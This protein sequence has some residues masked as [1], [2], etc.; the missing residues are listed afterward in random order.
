MT[1]LYRILKSREITLPTNVQLL[2]AVVFPVVIYGMWELDYKE[3]WVSK[4]WC[5]WTVVLEK[6]LENPLNCKGIQPV[7][8]KGNQSWIFIGRTDVEAETLIF[9]PPDAK[10]WLIGK[11]PDAGKGW[12]HVRRGRQRM[13]WLD[14]IMTQWVWVNYWSW[15]WI[16]RSGVLQSWDRKE[17]DDWTT[18][19]KST[20]LNAYWDR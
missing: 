1:N 20:E 9:W 6:P 19:L 17:S 4:N 12:R 2:K 11:D 8:P 15:W 7:H 10:N 16:R 18:E 13:R 14:G 5:F 3:S